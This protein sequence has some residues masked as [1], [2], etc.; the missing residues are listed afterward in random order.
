MKWEAVRE[1]YPDSWVLFEAIEAYSSNGKRIVDDLS[2]LNIFGDSSTALAAYKDIHKKEPNREL[3]V[4]HTDKEKID[5][6]ERKGKY[7][8]GLV[9]QCRSRQTLADIV[10]RQWREI[11]NEKKSNT[12]HWN[13]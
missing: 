11:I 12:Y 1:K 6:I 8:V 4:V 9:Q 5:I 3:Y 10:Y 13:N 7:S 2:V